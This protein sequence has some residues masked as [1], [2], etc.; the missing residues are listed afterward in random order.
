MR[1]NMLLNSWRNPNQLLKSSSKNIRN[2]NWGMRT[3][4]SSR[5]CGLSL[6]KSKRKMA[7]ASISLCLVAIGPSTWR[8]RLRSKRRTTGWLERQSFRGWRRGIS[9]KRWGRKSRITL[10][11]GTRH[12]DSRIRA[13]CRE[14][15]HKWSEALST[16]LN[17]QKNQFPKRIPRPKHS[18][19][20]LDFCQPWHRKIS[21][22]HRDHIFLI[23]L[24]D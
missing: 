3:S 5:N 1:L 23:H 18:P 6:R 14:V 19:K 24:A 21:S 9:R 16:M 12:A 7:T 11:W 17:P 8:S 15:Y 2:S 20:Q 22:P 4:A 10:S 13:T